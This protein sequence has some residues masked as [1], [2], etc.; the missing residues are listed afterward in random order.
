M[1]AMGQKRVEMK[2]E[3]VETGWVYAAPAVLNSLK[4]FFT[5]AHKQTKPG[6]IDLTLLI[7]RRALRKRILGIEPGFE[8]ILKI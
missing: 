3:R 4:D 1:K 2:I 6:T 7:A 5:L 8:F